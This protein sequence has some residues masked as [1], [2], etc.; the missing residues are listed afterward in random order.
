MNFADSINRL[1][2]FRKF[3]I[4]NMINQTLLLRDLDRGEEADSI[5][6][7]LLKHP[8]ICEDRQTHNLILRNLYSST[9]DIFLLREA[10]K[11]AESDDRLRNVRGLLL[12][13]MS[14]YCLEDGRF[15]DSAAYYA[16]RAFNE[17][18][19]VNN[20]FHKGLI[21][22]NKSLALYYNGK[23][24]SAY[25]YRGLFE[26]CMDSVELRNRTMEV[27]K[28]SALREAGV[29]ESR[30]QR[31]LY[32][33]N[34]IIL[35]LVFLSITVGGTFMFMLNRRHQRQKIA[36]METEMALEKTKRKIMASTLT[37]QEKDNV[38]GV[39][40]EELSEM[41]RDGKIAD[42]NARH[43]ESTIKVHLAEHESEETFFEMFDVVNPDFTCRLQ[44][45]TGELSESYLKLACYILMGLDNK[46]IA[47]LMMIKPES[48]RQSRWRLRQKLNL[49]D[50]ETMEG[51]L[52]SLN[53]SATS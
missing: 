23:I 13:L 27:M 2:G 16:D 21:Y 25:Y 33:R 50:T 1:L 48:V 34:M 29:A 7:T 46:K 30:Y 9:G 6:Y 37:I 42:T 36:A 8:V 45:R 11:D 5:L 47:R 17:V 3:A 28:L 18:E 12:T 49:S 4:K 15:P 51:V 38:L 39:L 19:Y 32:R 44:K 10:L 41:R 52:S 20:D 14:N 53:S 26:D 31:D 35:L 40:K 22:Y 43:L 24:D